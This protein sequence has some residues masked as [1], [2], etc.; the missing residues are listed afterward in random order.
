[1][2]SLAECWRQSVAVT[3]KARLAHKQVAARLRVDAGI[4]DCSR[5]LGSIRPREDIMIIRPFKSDE[6]AHLSYLVGD[7]VHLRR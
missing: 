5:A 6:L 7:G 4:E 1:V 3:A 2:G